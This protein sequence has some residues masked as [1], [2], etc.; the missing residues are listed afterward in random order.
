[1]R[2]FL[3]NKLNRR[4]YKAN[5]SGQHGKGMEHK[6]IAK[7]R[8]PSSSARNVNDARKWDSSASLLCSKFF[9]HFTFSTFYVHFVVQIHFIRMFYRTSC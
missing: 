7:S 6:S 1:M 4:G 2:S 9:P 3:V 8:L 5:K